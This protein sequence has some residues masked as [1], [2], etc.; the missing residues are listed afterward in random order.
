M[1]QIRGSSQSRAPNSWPRASSPGPRTRVP[2]PGSRFHPPRLQILTSRAPDSN[3]HGSKFQPPGLQ[4]PISTAPSSNLQGSR[5][6]LPQLQIPTSRAPDSNLHGSRFQP[7]RL[8]IPTSRDVACQRRPPRVPGPS[9]TREN[10]SE[11]LSTLSVGLGS[12]DAYAGNSYLC[13]ACTR[14]HM[15]Q[16]C[17]TQERRSRCP[18]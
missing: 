3:L 18:R 16:R 9:R 5:F 15:A 4:I 1:N 12:R 8:Q 17:P 13:I 2:G 6:Q 14:A 10:Q 7:P 11:P